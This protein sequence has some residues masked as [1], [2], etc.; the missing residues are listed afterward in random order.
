MDRWIGVGCVL[1]AWIGGSVFGN[2]FWVDGWRKCGS[3]VAA[4]WV[5]DGLFVYGSESS[6]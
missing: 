3:W 4:V 6:D 1:L 5:V 2:G